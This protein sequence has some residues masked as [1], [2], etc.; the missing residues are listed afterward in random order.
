MKND[1]QIS[2]L[3]YDLEIEKFK[4][5]VYLD[6]ILKVVER[7]RLSDRDRMIVTLY[8]DFS[9]RYE[10]LWKE[11][12]IDDE[13]EKDGEIHYETYF[14]KVIYD[15]SVSGMLSINV[16]IDHFKDS[17]TLSVIDESTLKI[18][19]LEYEIEVIRSVFGH[20]ESCDVDEIIDERELH[21]KVISDE[22]VIATLRSLVEELDFE[23]K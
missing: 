6:D 21:D 8:I 13:Y 4:V 3:N 14:D 22:C 2:I 9:T 23:I 19:K 1:L 11:I 16:V 17:P 7:E 18:E 10:D 20:L 12:E 15:L 5:T